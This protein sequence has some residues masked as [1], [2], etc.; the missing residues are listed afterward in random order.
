MYLVHEQCYCGKNNVTAC[1]S[2]KPHYDNSQGIFLFNATFA[3]KENM[4]RVR[5]NCDVTCQAAQRTLCKWI[6]CPEIQVCRSAT[7]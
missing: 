5:S 7:I 6:F 3:L 4:K 2:C 1:I